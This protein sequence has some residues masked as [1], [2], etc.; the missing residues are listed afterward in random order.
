MRMD[1]PANMLV[2]IAN[3]QHPKYF[4]ILESIGGEDEGIKNQR[5]G[6]RQNNLPALATEIGFIEWGQ[7]NM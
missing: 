4:S 5:T 7:R 1:I 3:F 2:N 6:S